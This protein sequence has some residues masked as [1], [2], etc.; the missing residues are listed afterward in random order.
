M[1]GD[2]FGVQHGVVHDNGLALLDL[3]IVLCV[4]NVKRLDG[5]R[6]AGI[7]VPKVAPGVHAF[8]LIFHF[9]FVFRWVSDSIVFEL[10]AGD[11]VVVSKVVP[12]QIVGVSKDHSTEHI[13][14]AAVL[15]DLG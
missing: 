8:D 1:G 9:G 6:E 7:L 5:L 2:I 14:C 3:E 13:S 11:L 12:L 4:G 10:L 15:V